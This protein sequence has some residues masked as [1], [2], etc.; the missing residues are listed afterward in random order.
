MG[1]YPSEIYTEL[2]LVP[3]EN[4]RRRHIN[5]IMTFRVI[6]A[7][8]VN[9]RK[10][11]GQ[12]VDFSSVSASGT[13]PC[14]IKRSF[15]PSD[16]KVACCNICPC[17]WVRIF[18]MW[19]KLRAACHPPRHDASSDCG[20]G[21]WLPTRRETGSRTKAVLAT[22]AEGCERGCFVEGRNC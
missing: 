5:R 21:R 13:V 14:S 8:R 22:V 2:Q 7:I 9:A 20:R 3:A 10:P 6:I 19:T 11:C 17:W 12:S 1:W 16:V 18:E 4:T 15:W